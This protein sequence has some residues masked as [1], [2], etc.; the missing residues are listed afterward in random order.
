MTARQWPSVNNALGRRRYWLLSK[1]PHCWYCGRAVKD[2]PMEER[3]PPP[4][5]FATIEHLNVRRPGQH[6]PPKGRTVLA[7][8]ECNQAEGAK[9]QMANPENQGKKKRHEVTY[10]PLT[11]SI[12]EIAVI[13]E[14]R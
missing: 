6:R 5:D 12:A 8:Y 11:S 2:Y 14:A 9:A 3:Y 1:D 10:T 13:R 4:G 7:C